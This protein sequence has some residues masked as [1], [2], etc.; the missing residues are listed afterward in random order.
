MNKSKK[1][2]TIG[3]VAIF[4]L[5][6]ISALS[7]NASYINLNS[8]EV[9]FLKIDDVENNPNGLTN[10]DKSGETKRN[11]VINFD[12]ILENIGGDDLYLHSGSLDGLDI[13]K[14]WASDP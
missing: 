4:L 5:T 14:D 6:I 12:L 7:A 10:I 8:Y 11:S 3:L 13:N 1:I 9:P 2:I